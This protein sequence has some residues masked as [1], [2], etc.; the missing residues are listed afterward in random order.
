M[1]EPANKGKRLPG[2][3][4]TADEVSALIR[5]CGRGPA[6]SGTPP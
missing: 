5:S 3:V 1:G 4:L 6:G 2:E